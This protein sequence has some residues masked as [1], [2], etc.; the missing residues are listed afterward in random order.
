MDPILE[1]DRV[2]FHYDTDA[3]CQ[4]TVNNV[5]FSLPRGQHL[6][7]LGA[8][9]SGKS[10]LAR[11]MNGLLLPDA[12]TVCVAGMD[13]T[14]ENLIYEIR[15]QCGM[16]FQNPDNQ[17][18]EST[19]A[20]D[21]AFGPSNLA[22]AA[23]EIRMRVDEALALTGLSELRDRA[24]HELSGGQ[25]QKLAIAGVLAMHPS[26]LVL[27]EATSMLDP[28][29]RAELMQLILKLRDEAGLSIVQITHYMEEALT[30]DYVLLLSEGSIVRAG[31]PEEIFSRPDEMRELQ[32]EVPPFIEI[33]Q[34]IDRIF[35]N[36]NA[37]AII[38]VNEAARHVSQVLVNARA[39]EFPEEI[40]Q[41]ELFRLQGMV[42]AERRPHPHADEPVIEVNDLSFS[43]D[44]N[45]LQKVCALD[46][47]NMQSNRG[48]I[49]GI[50]GVTGSGKSTF[51]QHLNGLIRPEQKGKVR[52][53]SLDLSDK[54]NVRQVR[55]MV[56]LLFQYPEDQLFEETVGL[57][58]AFGPKEM[59]YS[60]EELA[61][62]VERAA[63]ITGV[64]HLMD[65]S[66]FELS[67]GEQRRVAIA[68]VLALNPEILIMD[69]PSA[70]LDPAGREVIL[71]N[72][73][74]LAEAGKT[75]I[76]ISHDLESVARTADRLMIMS[77][78]RAVAIDT[79]EKIF[80][81]EGIL[82]ETGL[83][84]PTTVEFLNLIK[85]DWTQL[86]A[87]AFT[88]SEGLAAILS[89]YLETAEEEADG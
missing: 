22:L 39:E 24:P 27:D 55:R 33:T 79:P 37:A 64:S 46:Q 3:D 84:L 61:E 56:G 13:T 59:K 28:V 68:G 76:L 77:Q 34:N 30:A 5:S 44:E 14:D 65:R 53:L 41:D 40:L 11:L 16:V 80:A 86:Q 25:K 89:A 19:V 50:V 1:F 20:L 6:A 58:L 57:D 12:G 69:E 70:G 4:P 63:A 29:S 26:C 60:P 72:L 54:K 48:E 18:V 35:C 31:S 73:T 88:V 32:L 62:N 51:A 23:E 17:I 47:L 74:E 83:S 7:I 43:Y 9:G 78:G 38:D 71:N 2:S 49:L 87:S 52:V 45:P 82:A 10:T 67:G 42:K 75:V 85:K 21:V 81:T 8:N 15:R 66:P 36:D